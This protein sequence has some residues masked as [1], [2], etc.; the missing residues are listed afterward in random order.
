MNLP[1]RKLRD[2]L[3]PPTGWT[4]CAGQEPGT[5]LHLTT[6]C[7]SAD[8]SAALGWIHP[9]IPNHSLVQTRCL[10]FPS[11]PVQQRITGRDFGGIPAA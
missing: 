7:F 10:R 4:T 5:G 11:N 3:L 9:L 2:C 1:A 8:V 6:S